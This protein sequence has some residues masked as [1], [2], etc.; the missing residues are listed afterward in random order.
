MLLREEKEYENTELDRDM[1][2]FEIQEE[3]RR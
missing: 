1:L 2:N 3:K